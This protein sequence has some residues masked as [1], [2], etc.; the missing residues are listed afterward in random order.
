MK[1]T[2]MY[3]IV[4]INFPLWHLAS[5]YISN[6]YKYNNN[7]NNNYMYNNYI[8]HNNYLIIYILLII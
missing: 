1:C 4:Q 7:N 2:C 5:N 8:N 6:T 3:K